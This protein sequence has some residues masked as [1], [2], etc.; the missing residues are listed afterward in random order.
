MKKHYLI[1][2]H[3]YAKNKMAGSVFYC[4]TARN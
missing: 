4:V 1:K 3:A 2:T